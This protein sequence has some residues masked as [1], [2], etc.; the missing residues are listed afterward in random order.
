MLFVETGEKG[1][2]PPHQAQHVRGP[3]HHL[4]P[5]VLPGHQ[6]VRRQRRPGPGLVLDGQCTSQRSCSLHRRQVVQFS[7]F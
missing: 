5:H 6:M 4:H 2:V 7:I 1:V 3:V